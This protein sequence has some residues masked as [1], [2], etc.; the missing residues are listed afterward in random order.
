[1]SNS[2]KL[3]TQLAS[4]RLSSHVTNPP[5]L[6][7][8]RCDS[9]PCL[10][11]P[12]CHGVHQASTMSTGVPTSAAGGAVGGDHPHY[13]IHDALFFPPLRAL[14][15]FAHT[16]ASVALCILN[17]TSKY[18]QLCIQTPVYLCLSHTHTYPTCLLFPT[19]LSSMRLPF[20][21]MDRQF[22][23]QSSK[24]RNLGEVSGWQY[25]RGRRCGCTWR[26]GWRPPGQTMD[27]KWCVHCQHALHIYMHV[28]TR[29]HANVHFVYSRHVVHAKNTST[30]LTPGPLPL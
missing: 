24:K 5:Q 2:S 16:H 30:R 15:L 12:S 29:C 3:V 26:R 18:S 6:P 22:K 17:K 10:A 21:R 20:V 7:A 23:S 14:R 1:M 19:T 9:Q 11:P 27:D 25:R 13:K 4:S 8:D 28:T